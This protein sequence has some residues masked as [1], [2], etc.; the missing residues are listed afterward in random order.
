MPKH[1]RR[2]SVVCERVEPEGTWE[3][4]SSC[5]L[6]Q[7]RVNEKWIENNFNMLNQNETWFWEDENMIYT[8]DG[9]KLTCSREAYNKLALIVNNKWLNKNVK[10]IHLQHT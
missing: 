1:A 7:R 4:S 8:R 10:V 2:A 3:K 5:T 9:N 6:Q